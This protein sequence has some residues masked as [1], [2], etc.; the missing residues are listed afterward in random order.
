[1]TGLGLSLREVSDWGWGFPAGPGPAISGGGPLYNDASIVF[2]G[3]TEGADR[4]VDR[5]QYAKRQASENVVQDAPSETSHQIGA[6]R[7]E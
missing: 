2:S 7:V 1:M 4:K 6:Q 5:E 3:A